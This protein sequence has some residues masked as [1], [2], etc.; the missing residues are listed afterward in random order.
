M[1]AQRSE[2]KGPNFRLDLPSAD[3]RGK[4]SVAQSHTVS[5]GWGQEGSTRALSTDWI[6]VNCVDIAGTII[7]SASAEQLESH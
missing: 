3:G 5:P 2:L 6:G 7:E 1:F 4:F